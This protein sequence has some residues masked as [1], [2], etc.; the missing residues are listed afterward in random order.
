MRT[1]KI[2]DFKY[3][4]I[5]TAKRSSTTNFMKTLN[6]GSPDQ[7]PLAYSAGNRLGLCVRPLV[8]LSPA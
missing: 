4:S 3:S 2:V 8:L 6:A 7:S 5:A 1:N